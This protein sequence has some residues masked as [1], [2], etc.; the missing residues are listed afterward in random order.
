MEFYTLLILGCVIGMQH[1]LEADHL[2][3]VAALSDKRNSRRALVLRGSV[4][5]LGHTITLLTICGALLMFG[6]SISERT[7]AML[8]FAVGIMIIALGINVLVKL[9]RQRPHFHL[10][11][12]KHGDQHIHLH[13]HNDDLPH[14]RS[15]HAHE[16]SQL[17]LRRALVVGMVH[18]A[19]GSAGLLILAAAAE[20]L[21]HAIGYVLAF[22]TGSIIG[23]GA[24]T[25]VVSYPLQWMER[26]ATWVSTTAL[27]GVGCAA[28]IIGGSLLGQSWEVL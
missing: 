23:M 24:L 4:W 12:H 13:T 2:A 9:F 14:D 26:C 20:S 8:E 17:G 10:H 7:E 25:F 3:A 1:A 5:G 6:K 16:H 15:T 22:G 27:A 11:R 19:A 28:V 18:G 21:G